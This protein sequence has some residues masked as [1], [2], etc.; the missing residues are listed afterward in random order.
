MGALRAQLIVWL[1]ALAAGSGA[2]AHRTQIDDTPGITRGAQRTIRVRI[3]D[4]AGLPDDI[5]EV[6]TQQVSEIWIDR[7]IYVDR[8]RS[9]S[10][11]A[12]RRTVFVLIR[13][14]TPADDAL[15][16][17]RAALEGS[18]SRGCPIGLAWIAFTNK[19]PGPIIFVSLEHTQQLLSTFTYEGCFLDRCP[20]TL[21]RELLGRALG[22]I[23]AH[24]IGH[25]LNGPGHTAEGLMKPVL[26]DRDLLDPAIP[27]VPSKR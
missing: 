13:R 14:Q 15:A 5:R 26:S 23:A 24:E 1:I 8:S 17:R 3:V 20:P 10:Q 19:A 7:G 16:R 22:R 21:Y 6:V 12:V 4:G 9:D 27:S 18:P 25:Y 2:S 11:D